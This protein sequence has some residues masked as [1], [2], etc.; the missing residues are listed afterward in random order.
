MSFEVKVG[1]HQG[2]VL[3]PHDCKLWKVAL[4]CLWERIAGTLMCAKTDGTLTCAKTDG[5]LM[6]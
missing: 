3:S 2:S 5:T 4:W 1:L 6:C